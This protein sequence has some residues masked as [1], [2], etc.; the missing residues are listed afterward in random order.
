VCADQVLV[1]IVAEKPADLDAL[2]QIK[3]IGPKFLEKYGAA[4]LAAVSDGAARPRG[5]G[6][7]AGS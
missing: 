5:L 4:F 3:G 1:R 6:A 2:G 7:G